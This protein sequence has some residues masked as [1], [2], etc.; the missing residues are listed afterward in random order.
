MASTFTLGQVLHFGSQAYVTDYYGE[1]HLLNGFALVE[2]ELPA[3]PPPSGHPREQI[4]GP[5]PSGPSWI[6]HRPGMAGVAPCAQ[7]ELSYGARDSPSLLRPTE[8][9]GAWSTRNL[10]PVAWRV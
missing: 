6:D 3:L 9:G 7:A 2:S 1:L 4:S 5:R 8:V 10:P